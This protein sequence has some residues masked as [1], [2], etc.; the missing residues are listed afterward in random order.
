MSIGLL[1]ERSENDE[2][3]IKLTA[4]E[5]GIDLTF[6]PFRKIA[7]SIGKNGFNI[8]SKGKNYTSTIK[9]IAARSSVLRVICSFIG[10]HLV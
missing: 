7:V 10:L 4:E 3:G 2:N 6:I 1:Y 8:A 9:D 5:L